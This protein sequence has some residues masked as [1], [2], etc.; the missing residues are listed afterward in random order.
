MR[1]R[2]K[3]E[4]ERKRERERERERERV[5]HSL[6]MCFLVSGSMSGTLEKSNTS[7]T[8]ELEEVGLRS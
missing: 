4:R 8:E 3:G 7:S 6:P 5:G 2:E 1:G